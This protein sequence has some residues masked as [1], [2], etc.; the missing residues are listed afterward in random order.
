METSLEEI[1]APALPEVDAVRIASMSLSDST[2]KTQLLFRNRDQVYVIGHQAPGQVVNA[3]S[4]SLFRKE[5]EI[6]APIIIGEEDVHPSH[7]ALDNVMRHSWYNN[8]CNPSHIG[9]YHRKAAKRSKMERELS[10]V[11][12]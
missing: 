7:T 6:S 5:V 1:A 12:P 8:A 3:K 4:S 9:S 11:S 2:R 10:I